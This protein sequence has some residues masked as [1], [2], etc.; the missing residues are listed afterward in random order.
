MNIAKSMIK[1]LNGINL[2]TFF[3]KY[4]LIWY[5]SNILSPF[6]IKEKVYKNPPIKKNIEAIIHPPPII[7]KK[8]PSL[9]P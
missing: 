8:N 5:K 7:V 3:P 9:I 1:M 4:L 6:C 2:T